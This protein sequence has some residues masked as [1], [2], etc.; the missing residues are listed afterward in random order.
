VQEAEEEAI[1]QKINKLHEIRDRIIEQ[2]QNS[3]HEAE[4]KMMQRIAVEE[5]R[6]TNM[7]KEFT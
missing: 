3:L 6:N 2:S 4:V 7:F 5:E 1:Q